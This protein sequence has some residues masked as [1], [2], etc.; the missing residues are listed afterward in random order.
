MGRLLFLSCGPIGLA[1]MD[2]LLGQA[3][4]GGKQINDVTVVM[5]F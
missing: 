1:V 4:R 2:Y 3:D 5:R